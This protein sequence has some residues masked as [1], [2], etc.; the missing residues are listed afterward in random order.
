MKN[1]ITLSTLPKGRNEKQYHAKY[2]T[3]RPYTTQSPSTDLPPQPLAI[4]RS[5]HKTYAQAL[6]GA[7][8]TLASPN[9]D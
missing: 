2:S 8:P 5:Q 7:E 3:Q 6:R 1:N 4:P 9:V